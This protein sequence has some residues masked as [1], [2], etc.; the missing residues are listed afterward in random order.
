MVNNV[1]DVNHVL[2]QT[3]RSFRLVQRYVFILRIMILS[4][5]I[6]KRVIRPRA[7]STKFFSMQNCNIT[8]I[9]CLLVLKIRFVCH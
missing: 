2:P 3:P 1:L 9:I 8:K 5:G 6:T 7:I 4:F